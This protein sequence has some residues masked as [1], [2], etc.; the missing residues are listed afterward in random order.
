MVRF[1]AAAIAIA[2]LALYSYTPLASAIDHSNCD[3][4]GDVGLDNLDRFD[5]SVDMDIDIDEN[6]SF[7][8]SIKFKHDST[9]P[10]PT[11]ADQCDPTVQPP[12]M[13]SDGLP[14]YAFRW[15]YKRVPK[16]IKKAAGIDHITIDFNPCG[17]PPFNVFTIPHYDVHIYLVDPEYRACMTCDLV[18]SAPV[19]DPEKQTTSNGRGEFILY[20]LQTIRCPFCY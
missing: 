10:V 16:S 2:N 7:A 17:H 6:C 12:E 8:V 14:Y 3:S 1:Q 9:L 20:S 19:C 11:E 13:A 5:Y 4:I 18:Q 15:A